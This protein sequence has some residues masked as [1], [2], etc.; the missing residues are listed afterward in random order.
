METVTIAQ[1]IHIA[2]EYAMFSSLEILLL[3][4]SYFVFESAVLFIFFSD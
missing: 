4:K 2:G 3:H 1:I